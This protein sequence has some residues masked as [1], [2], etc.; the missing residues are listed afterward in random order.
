MIKARRMAFEARFD[1]S[2]ALRATQLRVQHR[3]QLVLRR[4][5]SHAL[6][7][8]ML[9]NKLLKRSPRDELQD[10]VQYCIVMAH[11]ADPFPCLERCRT[12]KTQKNPR[13]ALCPQN[14]S[15]TAV[16]LSRPSTS[17][18]PDRKDVDARHSPGMTW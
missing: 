13:H 15:R 3:D 9:I 7:C 2:Q 10:A 18:L 14:L 17:S 12:L 11:G 16:G 1:R 4:Q 8:P 5:P 6:V